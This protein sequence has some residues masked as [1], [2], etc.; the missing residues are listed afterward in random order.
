MSPGGDAGRIL[1]VGGYGAV[2]ATG[3]A[4][5]EQWFPGRVVP[6]GRDGER[7]R[8]LGGVRVDAG[9]LAGFGR[10]LDDLGDVSAVLLCVEP[11][12]AALARICLE[13]GVHFID[14]GAG[15]R[16]LAQVAQLDDLAAGSRAA[17]VLSV[18]VAPG[19][20]NLLARRVHEAVGGAERLDLTVLLGTGERH[21]ADAVRW[22][23][24][25]L[26]DP[27][28]ARSQ[29]VALPGYGVR[30][31]HPFP[32]SDQYTVRRTLD[33]REAT[34]RLC[35]DSRLLTATLFAVRR[36]GLLRGTHRP[37]QQRLLAQAFSRVHLGGEGFAV[38]ADARRGD[39]HAICALTGRGQSRVSGLVAAYVTRAVLAGGAPAGVRHIEQLP[40][41]ADLPEQLAVH[42]V[43]VHGI[44]N[45]AR[46]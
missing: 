18:G 8:R 5:L 20:T 2:G 37:G 32:F 24:A 27:V 29:R 34:T 22:T 25:G 33:V 4:M 44:T 36:L 16:L 30:R 39:R 15:H 40:V 3:T 26:S 14:V 9:D 17:A 28:L 46:R 23:V 7:A 21:G 41:L 31:A 38:R 43:T 42:G 19:L 12:D 11:E 13:R 35:L 10:V 6:G 45:G 1:V